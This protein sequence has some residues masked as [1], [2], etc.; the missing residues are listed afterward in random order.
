MTTYK[1]KIGNE[2]LIILVPFLIGTLLLMLNLGNRLGM[3]III[4]VILFT[5]YLFN[6]TNHQLSDNQLFVKAGFLWNIKID[7]SS[8]K[9]IT[10]IRSFISAPA[11]TVERLE[12]SYDKYDTVEIS[13]LEREDFIQHLTKLYPNIQ[14]EK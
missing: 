13:P 9:K 14:F 11:T 4:L 2:M 5:A 1:S 12:I 3:A 6:S 10:A 7:I 8:I